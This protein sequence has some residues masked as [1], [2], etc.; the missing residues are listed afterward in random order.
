[1][2]EE[3]NTSGAVQPPQAEK[4]EAVKQP[5]AP[6][7]KPEAAQKPA[8]KAAEE[9]KAERPTNCA[10]CKKAI[11]KGLWYYRNNKFYCSKSCWKNSSKKEKAEQKASA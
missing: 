2:N 9:K 10:A 6:A 3:K 5:E 1:M 7:G 11:R 8:E 4:T